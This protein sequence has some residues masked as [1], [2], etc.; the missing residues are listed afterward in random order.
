MKEKAIEWRLLRCES[1][2]V[3]TLVNAI[4]SACKSRK[5]I[6]HIMLVDD[7]WVNIVGYLKRSFI[8]KITKPLKRRFVFCYV[9]MLVLKYLLIIYSILIVQMCIDTIHST[10]FG[11]ECDHLKF[12]KGK[13][14]FM[15]KYLIKSVKYITQS[16]LQ[17][18][19]KIF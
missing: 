16:P 14:S 10:Q 7:Y 17:A 11:W 1:C 15:K 2:D 5:G 4:G 12:F 13:G 18:L 8:E 3:S 9:S 19:K 6:V